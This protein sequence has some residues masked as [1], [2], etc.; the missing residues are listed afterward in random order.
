ML[1]LIFLYSSCFSIYFPVRQCSHSDVY[2]LKN[3]LQTS[4]NIYIMMKIL[5]VSLEDPASLCAAK[6]IVSFPT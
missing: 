2:M 5:S 1:L 4:L 3:T 6:E